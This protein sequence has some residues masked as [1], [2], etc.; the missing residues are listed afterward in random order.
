M[1][2]F[3]QELMRINQDLAA[4]TRRAH[5]LWSARFGSTVESIQERA[6]LKRQYET[7]E[8]HISSLETERGLV[9]RA[10]KYEILAVEEAGEA[11]ASLDSDPT[12]E[13]VVESVDQALR[14]R[15]SVKPTNGRRRG[16]RP[17]KATAQ[18]SSE[19]SPAIESS[20][21]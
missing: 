10:M 20:Q 13:N 19:T 18:S 17:R 14:Q 8:A 1:T 12:D 21:S 2:D 6:E 15:S 7:V 16:G 3:A 4:A 5:E 11:S 9:Q